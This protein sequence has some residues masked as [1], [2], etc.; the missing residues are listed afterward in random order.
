[1]R[2]SPLTRLSLAFTLTLGLPAVGLAQPA[3]EVT[4]LSASVQA[5]RPLRRGDRGPAVRELQ[6]LLVSRG[7]A[8]AVDG[9]FGP[10]TE[11]AVRAAQQAGGLS[12]DG[13]VGPA[14]LAWLKGSS[15]GSTAAGV[16][17]SSGAVGVL[18]GATPPP[19]PPSSS[20][21]PAA[22]Y[23]AALPWARAAQAAGRHELIVVFEGLWAYSAANSA[24]IY[25]WQDALRAGQSP[26]APAS[27][28]LS[29]VSRQL[30][31]PNI[32][33]TL[34]RA[35]L[36]LLP[37]TSENGDSSV[38]EQACRA[39]RDVHGAQMKLI[40]VGHS[41]GG[42]SALRLAKKL[43]ARGIAI[44]GMLTVDART[45]PLNYRFFITPSNVREHL[46]YFQKGLWMPGYA[47]DGAQ[48]IRL[49]VNHGAIP[50]APQVVETYL[51]M[52]R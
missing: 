40:V 39:W 27:S 28:G 12:V 42:Y 10:A 3:G 2:A 6:Q 44:Q 48:N 36:L 17:A 51:R 7:R 33:T 38:A 13:V 4:N 29:F 16:S 23:S 9:D 20:T 22:A 43:E 45:T 37:E 50:G 34:D 25:A 26:P 5:G 21:A 11:A 46:N 49:H 31:V 30:I 47:I 8:I 14:T 18:T 52:V 41:F 1:M 24:R 19:G 15:A 32:R 35:E